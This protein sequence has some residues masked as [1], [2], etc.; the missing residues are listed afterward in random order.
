[1]EFVDVMKQR[2]MSAVTREHMNMIEM[3]IT[4]LVYLFKR[5]VYQCSLWNCSFSIN[6]YA[7]PF[8][9]PS[10]ATKRLLNQYMVFFSDHPIVFIVEGH[11]FKMT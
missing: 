8:C 2:D 3:N 10:V 7:P 9:V 4:H 1:M 6:N 11:S 5:T